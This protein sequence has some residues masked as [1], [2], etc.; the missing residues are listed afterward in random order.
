MLASIEKMCAWAG[1][2]KFG[3]FEWKDR[4][5][6]AT[7]KRREILNARIKKIFDTSDGTYGYRRIHAELAR[8]GVAA[9]LESGA[10]CEPSRL[11]RARSASDGRDPP[12]DDI[13]AIPD[14]VR[15]DFT[16]EAPYTK[17]I[18]DVTEI[19]TWRLIQKRLLDSGGLRPGGLNRWKESLR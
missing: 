2:S 13:A 5:P 15:R 12:A 7:A 10:P 18:G 19:K 16:A 8:G 11:V 14:L 17:L 3:Y 6:S 4:P 1:V 9:P